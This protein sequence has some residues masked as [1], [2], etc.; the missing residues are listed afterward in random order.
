MNLLRILEVF[1]CNFKA[2]IVTD[3]LKH[4]TVFRRLNVAYSVS[5]LSTL[6]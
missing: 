1:A 2:K 4:I 5:K 3:I 6:Q